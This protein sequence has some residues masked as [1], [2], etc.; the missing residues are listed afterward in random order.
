MEHTGA[1]YDRFCYG[2]SSSPPL[3]SPIFRWR[4]FLITEASPDLLINFL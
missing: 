3:L 4:G 1:F 2:F